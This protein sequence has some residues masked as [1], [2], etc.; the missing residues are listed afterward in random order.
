MAR[1]N[2]RAIAVV[3]HGINSGNEKPETHLD[4]GYRSVKQT[5]TKH[6]IHASLPS[7]R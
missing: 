7:L 2:P 4:S 3:N 5:I 6:F 1:L